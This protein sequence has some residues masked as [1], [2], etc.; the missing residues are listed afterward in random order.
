[1]SKQSNRYTSLLHGR[2]QAAYTTGTLLIRLMVGA[3]FFTEGLQKFLLPDVRGS[4][5]FEQIGFSHAEFWGYAVGTFETVCGALIL[6]GL[7]TRIAAVP[8]LIIMIVAIITTKI[9]IWIGASFGPFA[10][11]DKPY[12]GFLSMTH[13]MRTD[14][15][16]LLGSVFLVLVGGGPYSLDA[17]LTRRRGSAAAPS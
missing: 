15:S 8:T 12:Y 13:E 6:L 4:G 16:M 9:P 10:L 11:P 17:V 7:L 2:S 5:R 14:W 1:M 3:V